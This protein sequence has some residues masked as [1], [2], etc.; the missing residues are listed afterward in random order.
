MQPKAP[1]I[2]DLYTLEDHENE[3]AIDSVRQN[4]VLKSFRRF[5][6]PRR[7]LV[8]KKNCHNEHEDGKE[9]G[10]NCFY[11]FSCR[12]LIFIFFH[13]SDKFNTKRNE[14]IDVIMFFKKQGFSGGTPLMPLLDPHQKRR[15]N[16][17]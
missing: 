11:C 17:L 1:G 2:Y 3:W 15:K 13:S 6:M 4:I 14:F 8:D 5:K 16:H 9:N 12:N 7:I 10:K